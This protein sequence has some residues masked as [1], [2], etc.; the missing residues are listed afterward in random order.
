[1]LHPQEQKLDVSLRGTF[2]RLVLTNVLKKKAAVNHVQ[3]FEEPRYA[4][5]ILWAAVTL[6]AGGLKKHRL[7]TVLF[8]STV[9]H[10]IEQLGGLV[11]LNSKR[12]KKKR[13]SG[14]KS[15]KH[16]FDIVMTFLKISW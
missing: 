10:V 13:N 1:M 11:A 14:I 6:E 2:I 12:N 15:K 5:H 9:Y 4:Y 16:T 7:L 8:V 3:C